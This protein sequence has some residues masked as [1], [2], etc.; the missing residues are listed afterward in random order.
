MIQ[1][2][3]NKVPETR[4]Q[5][6]ELMSMSDEEYALWLTLLEERNGITLPELRKDRKSVV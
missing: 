5:L 3:E 1:A 2:Q 6:N 4:W